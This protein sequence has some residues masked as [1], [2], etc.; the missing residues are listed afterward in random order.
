M[1]QK[2]AYTHQNPVRAGWVNDAQQYKYS[3][4]L[5]YAGEIG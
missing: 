2:I 5:D 4:A 1:Q 3:S